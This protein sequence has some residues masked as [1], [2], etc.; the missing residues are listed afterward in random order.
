MF[1]VFM[2]NSEIHVEF[3]FTNDRRQGNVMVQLGALDHFS[4]IKLFLHL[5]LSF[6]HFPF[7]S[8]QQ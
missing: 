7:R 2:F 1:S 5:V 3:I 8:Y 6:V 4:P